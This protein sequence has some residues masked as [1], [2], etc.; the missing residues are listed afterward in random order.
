MIASTQEQKLRELFL[1]YSIHQKLPAGA[2]VDLIT[3]DQVVYY[4]PQIQQILSENTEIVIPEWRD[5]SGEKDCSEL[6]K[7]E[8]H[9]D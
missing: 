2:E 9:N 4:I 3:I 8:N 6:E 1:P 5:L 7:K